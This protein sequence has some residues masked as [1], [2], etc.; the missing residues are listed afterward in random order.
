MI[1]TGRKFL[2]ERF[3]PSPPEYQILTQHAA[4]AEQERI[5]REKWEKQHV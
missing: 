1:S 2:E 3:I 4:W 5:W